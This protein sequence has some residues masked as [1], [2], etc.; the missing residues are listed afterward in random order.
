VESVV[1][2]VGVP[3]SSLFVLEGSSGCEVVVKCETSNGTLFFTIL[4]GQPF[5]TGGAA[6]WR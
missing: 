2:V 6:E 3:V 1:V 5:L 4:F